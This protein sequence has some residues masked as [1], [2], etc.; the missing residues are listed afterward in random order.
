LPPLTTEDDDIPPLIHD[1]SD[2]EDNDILPPLIDGDSDDEDNDILPPLIDGDSDD[3]DNDTLPPLI[4]GDSDDEDTYAGPRKMKASADKPDLA[5]NQK[6]DDND[7]LNGRFEQGEETNLMLSAAISARKS[8]DSIIDSGASQT[9]IK[10]QNLL[11]ARRRRRQSVNT[12][13]PQVKVE[14]SGPIGPFE[15]VFLLPMLSHNLISVRD[16]NDL[17]IKVTFEEGT[18]SLEYQGV[19]V[20]STRS[21]DRVWKC[22]FMELCNKILALMPEGERTEKWWLY[23]NHAL[24]S[25]RSK[26]KVLTVTP[27]ETDVEDKAEDTIENN[28]RKSHSRSQAIRLWHQR[29]CHRS[30]IMIVN[31]VNAGKLSIGIPQL[32]RKDVSPNPCEC[33]LKAKSH[34]LPRQARPVVKATMTIAKKVVNPAFKSDSTEQQGFGPGIVSTDSCGPYTVPSL[35]DNFVGNQNFM[36]MDSKLVFCYGY[37]NKTAETMLKKSQAFA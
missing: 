14:M 17:G 19:I 6:E 26:S 16:L 8:L 36:L 1:D 33:C 34:K 9:A 3:E 27:L 25:T 4:D 30:E 20:L 29:L 7:D 13:G 35:H 32:S 12:V 11:T 5:V 15:D 10:D 24:V 37:V 31:E 18:M 22:D 28:M 2:D 23:Q 21:V